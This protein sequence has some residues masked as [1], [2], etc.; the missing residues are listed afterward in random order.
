MSRADEAAV[1]TLA[2]DYWAHYLAV[3]PTEA[4]ISATTAGAGEFE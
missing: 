4:H 3:H 2:E 1:D